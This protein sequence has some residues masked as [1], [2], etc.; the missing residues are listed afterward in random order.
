MV[1]SSMH[2]V[3]TYVYRMMGTNAKSMPE[4]NLNR[5]VLGWLIPARTGH[6]HFADNH[7]RLGMK[8]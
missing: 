8:K 2:V 6:G 5:E 7:D 3:A 4:M 1:Y